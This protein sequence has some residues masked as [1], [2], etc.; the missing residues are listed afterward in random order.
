MR[1]AAYG[2]LEQQEEGQAEIAE[3]LTIEPNFHEIGYDAM[4]KLFFQESS[5]SKML[6]GLKK[7]GL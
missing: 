1:A 5:T 3:L 2:Q 4:I 7:A 6:E